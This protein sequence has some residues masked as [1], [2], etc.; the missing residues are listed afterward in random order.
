MKSIRSPVDVVFS[1]GWQ[2]V[3]DDQRNLLDVNAT[4]QQVGG[5]QHPGG[6]SPELPHDHITLLLVHVT[7][8]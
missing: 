3:V 4:G 1:V 6:A 5:D 2:I 8:L 7:V